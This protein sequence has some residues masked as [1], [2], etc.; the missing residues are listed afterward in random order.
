MR[1]CRWW[2]LSVLF[3]VVWPK[4]TAGEEP[5][6]MN[7]LSFD[8]NSGYV[9]LPQNLFDRLNEGTIEVWVKWQSFRNWS[10][11]IDFGHEENAFVVQNDKK[12][13]TINF[14]IWDEGGHRHRIQAKKRV[15]KGV[16]HHLAMVFGR[17]GMAFYIDGSLIGTN[18]FEG[19]PNVSAG[20]NNYIGRSNWPK[21]QLFRGQMAELRVWDL[22]LSQD[23]LAQVK[24]RILRRYEPG[25][26]GYW[27]L[28]SIVDNRVPS[29]LEMGY[30]GHIGG[31][32]MIT[33][34]PAIDR[35]LVPGELEKEADL[36][37]TCG[38]AAF[39]AGDHEEAIAAFEQARSYVSGYK[40]ADERRR[41]AQRAWD[42][43]VAEAAY[44]EGEARMAVRDPV[45]AY[46]AFDRAVDS[47]PDFRDAVTKRQAALS[48]SYSVGLFLL[49]SE[50]IQ[51]SLRPRENE[52]GRWS[53]L[54]SVHR[55]GQSS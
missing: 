2:F 47:V 11:V 16:W 27:R 9:E 41:E 48:A 6:L 45:R 31:R 43:D 35:F 14:S 42:L 37:Y 46:W 13:D 29:V 28:D 10:R 24:G 3:V 49:S 30:P 25:L 39:D 44:A 55:S 40:D 17:S 21:D 22:R 32:L 23:D 50:R 1:S 4:P 26:V 19:G 20:G 52:A 51:E 38:A 15:R 5:L 54:A 18:D 7:V 53:R 33:T 36:A 34:I 8:G 12:S